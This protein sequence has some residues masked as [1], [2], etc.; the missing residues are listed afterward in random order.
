MAV[1]VA[2]AYPQVDVDKVGKG[3]QVDLGKALVE[4][5]VSSGLWIEIC[6]RASYP[7]IVAV[8][9]GKPRVIHRNDVFHQ[10]WGGCSP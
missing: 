3:K 8:I 9:H 6:V 7:Q 1:V 10:A 4:K 2:M 5:L